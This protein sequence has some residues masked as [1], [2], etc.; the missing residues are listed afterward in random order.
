MAAAKKPEKETQKET[1][2]PLLNSL[3]WAQINS[4][5]CF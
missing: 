3:I 4:E 1:R 5:E 2:F